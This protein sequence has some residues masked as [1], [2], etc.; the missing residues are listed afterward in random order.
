MVDTLYLQ[1]YD[2]FILVAPVAT[3]VAV[4]YGLRPLRHRGAHPC[5]RG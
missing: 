2:L 1:D 5:F 3:R 4:S